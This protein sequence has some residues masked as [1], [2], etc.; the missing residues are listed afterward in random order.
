MSDTATD[1][2][3]GISGWV[4]TTSMRQRAVQRVVLVG[5]HAR[6]FAKTQGAHVLLFLTVN[7]IFGALGFL[8][9]I[10][11]EYAATSHF[12]PALKKQLDAA[13]PYTFSIAFLSSTVVYVVAEYL[14]REEV[15]QFRPAKVML[16][17][18]AGLI[19]VC[20][21][22]FSGAQTWQTMQAP[23]APES[24]KPAAS[25][26]TGQTIE[27]PIPEA[28]APPEMTS[29]NL[30]R[31]DRLQI[32]VTLAAI[33]VG[34]ALFLLFQYQSPSMKAQIDRFASKTNADAATLMSQLTIGES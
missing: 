9:P 27:R 28:A 11:I 6:A 13:G 7:I 15:A 16:S 18:A 19:I 10:C 33:F 30:S 14:D 21:A 29:K 32:Y 2:D 31:L 5:Q 22:L 20:C 26:P 25:A 17:A 8:S 12:Y 4:R 3:S 1:K 23:A 34:L 24:N